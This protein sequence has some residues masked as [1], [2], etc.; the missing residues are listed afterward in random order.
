MLVTD[1]VA[2]MFICILGAVL[3]ARSD[4]RAARTGTHSVALIE[5]VE[6]GY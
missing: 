4:S 6:D 5:N 2:G 1:A 3:L